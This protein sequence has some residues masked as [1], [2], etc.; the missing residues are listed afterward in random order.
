MKLI[1]SGAL[2]AGYAIVALFFLKFWRRTSDRLFGLFAAAFA[3]LALQRLGLSV[4]A[5]LA[6]QGGEW[7]Y[8]LRLLAFVL[9]LYA[10]WDKN[11]V[12][13]GAERR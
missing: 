4:S 6:G 2:L 12:R 1:V 9:I 7:M 11:R 3:L 8:V 5:E 10:I 13:P